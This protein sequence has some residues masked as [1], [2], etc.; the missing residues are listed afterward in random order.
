[1]IGVRIG[2]YGV[3]KRDFKY[4]FGSELGKVDIG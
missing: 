1:M 4:S 3:K 2:F